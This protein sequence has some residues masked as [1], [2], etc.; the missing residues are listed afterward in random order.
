MIRVDQEIPSIAIT[1]TKKSQFC[2]PSK[3]DQIARLT[4]SALVNI[5]ALEM[6]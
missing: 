6:S 5:N 2:L 4:F 3:N 1:T